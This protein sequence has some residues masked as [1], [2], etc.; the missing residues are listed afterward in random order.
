MKEA[1]TSPPL[2]IAVFGAGKIGSTFAYH[3]ARAGHDLTV[4]ARPGSVRLEQLQ[5]DQGIV[6]HTGECAQL[7]VADGLDEETPYDL[8]VVTVQA[9]QIDAVLPSLRRSKARCIHFMFV[10]F[11]PERLRQAAGDHRCTFGMPVVMAVLDTEGRLKATIGGQKTKHSDPRWADLFNRAGIPSTFEENMLLWLR[12]HV[13]LAIAMESVCAAGQ[14]RGS[15]SSWAE[16]MIVARGLHG[17]FEIIRALGYHLYPASKSFIASW[18]EFLIALMLWLVS[19]ITSFRELLA[20]GVDEAVALI[21]VMV[22]AAGSE[23]ERPVPAAVEAVL[24]MKFPQEARA[25]ED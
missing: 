15:G 2:S 10:T 24:A 11:E 3:L 14:R 8:L 16:A 7:T 9:Y 18:P 1:T 20:Q 25:A 13:P 17:G 4:V 23:A 5:R 6:L 12:C 22:A 19:R 21:D